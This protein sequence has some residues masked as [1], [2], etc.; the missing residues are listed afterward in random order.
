MFNVSKEEISKGTISNEE[1]PK[2]NV[3]LIPADLIRLKEIQKKE[4]ILGVIKFSDLNEHEDLK[5]LGED[6]PTMNIKM[7]PF[8]ENAFYEIWTSDQPIN[9]GNNEIL[10]F[11]CDGYHHFL[12]VNIKEQNR[13]LREIGRLAYDS[14]FEILKRNNYS[15]I[16]RVWNHIPNINEFSDAK[17][18]YTKFCHGRAESFEVNGNIYPAATG[19]GCRGD[20]LCIYMLST[21]QNIQKYIENPNQTPAYK[22][23]PK[24]G[25][26]SPSFARATY[27]NYNSLISRL[28]ISGTAS[29][30]GSDTV[31][32]GNVGKQ[33]ETTLE[34]IRVLIS[35]SNLSNY[36][37]KENFTL[38]NID[39]IKVY[40]KN[41][42]DFEVIKDICSN[43]FSKNRSIAY[44]KADVC[45]NDLLVEIEGIVQK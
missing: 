29:I 45:R 43:A 3:H 11:A 22:Y 6:L 15:N 34:N 24:Y 41:N 1:F 40:I 8:M 39:C 19:I 26:K 20:S 17:E 33:C 35:S 32:V 30:L 13:D 25:I 27:T 2:V 14:I 42:E 5:I 7:K 28:Y 21:V 36:G 18:R 16:S 12:T 9:Y 4:N 37:I 23:P 44:L 10:K 31:H 38:D